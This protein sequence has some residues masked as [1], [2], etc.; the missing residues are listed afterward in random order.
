VRRAEMLRL[1]DAW[2]KV[3]SRLPARME[4]KRKKGEKGIKGASS[5]LWHECAAGKGT[6]DGWWKPLRRRKKEGKISIRAPLPLLARFEGR[7]RFRAFCRKYLGR[8]GGG[9]GGGEDAVGK[10]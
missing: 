5:F 2:E 3:L 10:L 9:R 1:A 7:R 8:K 6:T 4:K